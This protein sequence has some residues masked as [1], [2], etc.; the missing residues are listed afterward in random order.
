MITIII[1]ITSHFSEVI[2]FGHPKKSAYL[3]G[4]GRKEGRVLE[5]RNLAYDL[6]A[7]LVY[8]YY[9]QFIT[10]ITSQVSFLSL[11]VMN[12]GTKSRFMLIS[13][14]AHPF[15]PVPS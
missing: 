10:I 4:G 12:L 11:E 7:T 14:W 6:L 5:K 1:I 2:K 15:S 8:G 3:E 9:H 13:F